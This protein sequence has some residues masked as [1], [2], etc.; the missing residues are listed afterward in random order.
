MPNLS[1]LTWILVAASFLVLVLGSWTYIVTST[2]TLVMNTLFGSACML[3][4]AY[5]QEVKIHAQTQAQI[6]AHE[7]WTYILPFLVTMLLIGRVIGLVARSRREAEWIPASRIMI[8]AALVGVAATAC[9]FLMK[10]G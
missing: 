10:A 4:A 3:F 1:F 6:N 9:A 7:P 5:E 8:A 2:R